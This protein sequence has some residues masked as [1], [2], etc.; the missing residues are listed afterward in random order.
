MKKVSATVLYKDNIIYNMTVNHKGALIPLVR[1]DETNIKHPREKRTFQEMYGSVL[2]IL[3]N[4]GFYVGYFI[5]FNAKFYD[6]QFININNPVEIE[7]MA[8]K[9]EREHEI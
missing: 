6:I 4:N 8:Y 3:K 9:E 7:T 2:N 5:A 1:Y